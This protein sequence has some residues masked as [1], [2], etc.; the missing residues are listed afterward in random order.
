MAVL[1]SGKIQLQGA[2]QELLKQMEGRVWKKTIAKE[3]LEDHRA[4]YEVISTRLFAGQT[5]IHVLADRRPGDGFEPVAGGLEDVYF[6]T[7][8]ASRKVAA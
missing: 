8:T 3:A 7:L 1:A 4:R 6:S 2:P 5:V